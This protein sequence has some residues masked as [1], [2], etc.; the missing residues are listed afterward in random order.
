M[1]RRDEEV[2]MVFFYISVGVREKEMVGLEKLAGRDF[3]HSVTP[4]E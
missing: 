4:S 1:E 3:I 2:E